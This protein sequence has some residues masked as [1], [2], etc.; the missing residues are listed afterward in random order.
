M[1]AHG[2]EALTALFHAKE[3]I[4]REVLTACLTRYDRR[5]QELARVFATMNE[6]PAGRDYFLSLLAQGVGWDQ[7]DALRQLMS[8]N[9]AQVFS[10]AKADIA[11]LA[12]ASSIV[13]QFLRSKASDERG[14]VR[15][16]ADA[17]T[18]GSN[19]A[20]ATAIARSHTTVKAFWDAGHKDVVRAL[21]TAG[22]VEGGGG[23]CSGAGYTDDSVR[24]AFFSLPQNVALLMG[25]PNK[26]DAEL[27]RNIPSR[28]LA[29]NPGLGA[30][31]IDSERD[32]LRGM[33]SVPPYQSYEGAR[34]LAHHALLSRF[35]QTGDASDRAIVRNLFLSPKD[36]WQATMATLLIESSDGHYFTRFLEQ[37]GGADLVAGAKELVSAEKRRYATRV[38]E[39][40]GYTPGQ[41]VG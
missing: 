25:S 34:L 23:G 32:V 29:K 33:L 19:R 11:K 7:P 40:L 30:L 28:V 9:R 37:N 38:L 5:P 41:S 3:P 26:G 14:L 36:P 2:G 27:I 15:E 22:A 1:A 16:L 8:T 24:D 20:A 12:T 13:E 31:F 17:I 21:A 10:A 4:A 6:S 35:W 39:D 18:R